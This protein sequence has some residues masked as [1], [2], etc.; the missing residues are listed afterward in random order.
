MTAVDGLPVDEPR[1]DDDG[2]DGV[3]ETHDAGSAVSEASHESH[4]DGGGVDDRASTD[5]GEPKSMI[6]PDEPVDDASSATGSNVDADGA[7]SRIDAQSADVGSVS[8]EGRTEMSAESSNG[9]ALTAG[10]GVADGMVKTGS[11]V[12]DDRDA[13]GGEDDDAALDAESP[14]T[15]RPSRFAR[16][17]LPPLFLRRER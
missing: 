7:L 17:F 8:D 1:S 3:G 2:V 10:S 9:G 12:D 4:D 14:L 11:G 6:E 15:V 16:A 5:A 13:G